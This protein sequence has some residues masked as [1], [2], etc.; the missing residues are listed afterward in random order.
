MNADKVK[1]IQKK[2]NRMALLLDSGGYTE[3][4]V[5]IRDLA[6]QYEHEPRL[7]RRTLLSFYGGM[8]S[9]NDVL[10]YKNGRLLDS[11]NEELDQLRT[12]VFELLS[13]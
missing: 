13:W 7:V 11:E 12:D 5:S 1:L 3:W 4:S 9:L 8:G 6:K 10:L 2:L